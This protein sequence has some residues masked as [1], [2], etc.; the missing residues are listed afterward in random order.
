MLPPA[1]LGSLPLWWEWQFRSW[2]EM[3][4]PGLG[5]GLSP[6]VGAL[7]EWGHL[8]SWAWVP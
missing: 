2:G 1:L 8:T 6:V 4:H 3:T 7:G 5:P